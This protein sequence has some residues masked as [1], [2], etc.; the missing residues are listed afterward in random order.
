MLV[1]CNGMLR[2]GSTCQYNLARMVAEMSGAGV[3]HTYMGIESEGPAAD[4]WPV[5]LF[6]ACI[7]TTRSTS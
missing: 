1:L 4:A 6:R 3:A 2:S 5:D 7:F